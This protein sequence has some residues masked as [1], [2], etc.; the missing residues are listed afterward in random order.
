M[1]LNDLSVVPLSKDQK[2]AKEGQLSM[3]VIAKTYRY[4]DAN[5]IAARKQA[6][7]GAQK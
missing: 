3:D 6:T 4:L 1:T 5:E 7:K 2:E